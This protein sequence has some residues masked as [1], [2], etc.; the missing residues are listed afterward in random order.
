MSSETPSQTIC[1]RS[2]T[3]IQ[4]TNRFALLGAN[5]DEDDD[6]NEEADLYDPDDETSRIF[7]QQ[8]SAGATVRTM[9]PIFPPA[10][11]FRPLTMAAYP[12]SAVKALDRVSWDDLITLL[13]LLLLLLLLS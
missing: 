8:P 1:D 9:Q 6:Q 5:D 11:E 7:L 12:A 13:L 4:K 3:Q 10:P 2:A